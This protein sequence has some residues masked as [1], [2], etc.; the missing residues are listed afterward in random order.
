[1]DEADIAFAGVAGQAELIRNGELSSVELTKTLL[2]RIERL[3]PT[4]N[5]FR[6]VMA[7]EALAEAAACDAAGRGD[8]NGGLHGVPIAIKDELDVAGQLTTFG[9]AARTRPAAADCELVAR[10]RAAGAVIAGKTTMPEFGQW[11]FSESAAFGYT[12]NP[13]NL[14][15]T[16]GGSSGGTASAVAAG[17]VAAGIGGDG[18]GSIRIPSA[19]CGLFG[20]KP[21]RLLVS[22]APVKEL[23]HALGTLGPLTRSVED[24]ALIYDI[25]RTDTFDPHA[26]FAAAAAGPAPGPLRI[27]LSRKPAQRGVHLHPEQARA[28]E[29]AAEALRAL[30]HE[31]HETDP[32]YPEL[33]PAFVPQFYGGVR[34]EVA[35]VE[36]PELLER[37]TKQTLALSRGFP[38]PTVRWA[39]RHGERIAARVNRL[40]D[41]Y[42]ALLTPTIA[43]MPRLLGAL[44]GIGSVHA[45]LRALPYVAYTAVWNVCGNPAASI[46]VGFSAD[47]LPRAVQL[48]A[49][50]HYEPT[51]FQLA[52][53]LEAARPWADRR[54]RE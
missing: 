29:D 28:L 38:A 43:S 47:G 54:P 22:T 34:D 32:D 17:L 52:A 14:S 25:I 8:G 16:T 35:L 6:I 31:V 46:P 15:R 21:T 7:D 37:R 18:G 5:A 13:W 40:F 19:C 20:L 26:G 41:T 44:D 4:L 11:P 3:N 24:S 2:K 49:R 10:L 27:A 42:D 12:R 53:Q 39:V 30:G 1:M 33:A 36:A 51:I 9:T 50:P 45:S 23:W 48:I